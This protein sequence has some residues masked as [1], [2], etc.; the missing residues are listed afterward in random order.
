MGRA[1]ISAAAGRPEVNIRAAVDRA[2]APGLGSEVA[3]GVVATTELAAALAACD[4]Y[5]DFTSPAGTR[6][7][8]NAARASKCAAVIGTTGLTEAENTAIAQLV[9]VAPV[10]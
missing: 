9:E 2:D 5:I 10:V 4:V 6:A 3:P 8:A 7:A 1:I